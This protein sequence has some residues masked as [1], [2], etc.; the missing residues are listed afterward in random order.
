MVTGLGTFPLALQK[1]FWFSWS[2]LFYSL[3]HFIGLFFSGPVGFLSLDKKQNANRMAYVTSGWQ[4]R[5]LFGQG[6][7]N[8]HSREQR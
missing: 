1:Y 5:W 2:D 8:W 7:L 4:C 6:L 3:A